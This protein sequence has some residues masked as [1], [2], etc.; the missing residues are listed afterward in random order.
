MD[1]Q[2]FR[3][4]LAELMALEYSCE[5]KPEEEGRSTP[6][7]RSGSDGTFECISSK[8]QRARHAVTADSDPNGTGTGTTVIDEAKL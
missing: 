7:D 1:H 2:S 5:K 8:R 6:R 3:V 4:A